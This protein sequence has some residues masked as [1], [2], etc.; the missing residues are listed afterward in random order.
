MSTTEWNAGEYARG[1]ALQQG[2]AEEV[3]AEIPFTGRERVL[4]IGCGDGKVTAEVAARVPKGEVRGID[5]ARGMIAYAQEKFGPERWANLRFALGDARRMEYRAEFDVVVSF[6]ALHWVHEQAE[7]LRGIAAA[8]KPGGRAYLRFVPNNPPKSTM[9]ANDET[10]QQW[11]WASAFAGHASPFAKFTPEEY[12]VL[13]EGAGLKVRRI[14]VREKVWEFATEE[15][16]RWFFKAGA[17]AWTQ[18]LAEAEVEDF[19]KEAMARHRRNNG[20]GTEERRHRFCQM[21]VE[22]EK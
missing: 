12:R 15:D 8:L 10:S 17:V 2:M 16:Y 20:M 1:S 13:A 9:F 14:E 3:L 19:V 4:D 21:A 22:L 6:N 7:V 5:P 18:R 11:R